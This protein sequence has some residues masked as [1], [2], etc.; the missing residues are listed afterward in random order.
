MRQYFRCLY[1]N[2]E[3]GNSLSAKICGVESAAVFTKDQCLPTRDPSSRN[4][5]WSLSPLFCD[6]GSSLVIAFGTQKTQ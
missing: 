2:E 5:I 6:L 4:S 1:G 3:V